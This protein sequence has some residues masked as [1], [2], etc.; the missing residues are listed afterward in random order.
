VR[1]AI[2][3]R[4]DELN[5]SKFEYLDLY[6]GT[7]L[8]SSQIKQYEDHVVSGKRMSLFGYTGTSLIEDIALSFAKSDLNKDKHAT[9]YHIKWNKGLKFCW[10][11]DD[12]AY[13]EEKEV[14][15]MDGMRFSV[16][17]VS[18]KTINEKHVVLI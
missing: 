14:L 17:S 6:R 15:L 7:S 1:W 4:E 18:K 11:Y 12:S 8:T 10:Y 16:L 5:E 13:P 3:N 9:L 2:G